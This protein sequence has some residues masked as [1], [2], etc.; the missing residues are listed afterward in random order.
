MAET[1]WT[2]ELKKEVIS[3]YKARNPTPENTLEIIKELAEEYEKTPNGIRMILVKAQ[4]YVKKANTTS[5]SKSS[6][7]SSKRVNKA[8]AL[9]TLKEKIS[10]LDQDVDNDI[11]DRM[12][13]KA[14]VYFTGI[15]E[16][17]K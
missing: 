15:L 1:E 16:N 11:I 2:D 9:S 13:G 7:G 3:E 8:E 14:A 12:T 4:A 5:E 10:S 6:D 17:I